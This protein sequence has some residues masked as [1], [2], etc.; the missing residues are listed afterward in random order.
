MGDEMTIVDFAAAAAAAVH[1]PTILI[2]DDDKL[3]HAIIDRVLNG[4]DALVLH[5]HDGAEG[6]RIAQEVRPDLII[7]DAL[8]PKIDGREVAKAVKIDPETAR[9]RVVVMTA[10]YK[11]IRYRNE[12]FRDFLVDGYL[13]KPL[14]ATKIHEA[15]GATLPTARFAKSA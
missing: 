3:V 12:A 6:L 7:T 2:I 14:T 8:L 13:E 10:L 5:A 1:R 9:T 15:I 11:G 4:Y